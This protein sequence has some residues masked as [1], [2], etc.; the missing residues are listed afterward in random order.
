MLP[1]INVVVPTDEFYELSMDEARDLNED[2]NGDPIMGEDF[3]RSRGP[4]DDGATFRIR[5]Y[6]ADG[7]TPVY[8]YYIAAVPVGMGAARQPR[9]PDAQPAGGTRTGWPCAT[10]LSPTFQFPTG[11]G[12]WSLPTCE[13]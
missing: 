8:Q 1:R 13:R 7:V 3:G 6:A 12:H 10:S 5:S 11:C 4:S 9:R 2:G